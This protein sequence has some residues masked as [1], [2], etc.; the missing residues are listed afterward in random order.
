MKG[1]AAAADRS[2]G[3][4]FFSTMN[5]L[6]PHELKLG[7]VVVVGEQLAI[8]A[9]SPLS[10][11]WSGRNSRAAE[12]SARTHT[13]TDRKRER[14]RLDDEAVVSWLCELQKGS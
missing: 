5:F 1:S 4:R 3:R 7:A 6:P 8:I 11:G 10:L 12:R 14:R 2:V 13:H 9:H